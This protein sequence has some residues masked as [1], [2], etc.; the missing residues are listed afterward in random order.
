MTVKSANQGLDCDHSKFFLPDS[1]VLPLQADSARELSGPIQIRRTQWRQR[2]VTT[3]KTRAVL[4]VASPI[5]F[6]PNFIPVI[7]QMDD[8]A[9][10]AL[11]IK[12][13][14][15]FVPADVMDEC[16]NESCAPLDCAIPVSAAIS[17]SPAQINLRALAEERK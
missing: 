7:G 8:V 13:L 10:I 1:S 16:R 4:Y 5:Q 11:S 17:P 15:R 14:K 2:F 6:I 9:V 3:L 12:L